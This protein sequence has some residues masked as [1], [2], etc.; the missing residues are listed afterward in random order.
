MM[1]LLPLAVGLNI[2]CSS[3]AERAWLDELRRRQEGE[4]VFERAVEYRIN[5]YAVSSA[6]VP[7]AKARSLHQWFAT[8][9]SSGTLTTSVATF[10][11][12]LGAPEPVKT[13]LNGQVYKQRYRF[14]SAGLDSVFFTGSTDEADLTAR[15]YVYGGTHSAFS[16]IRL[17]GVSSTTITR[18]NAPAQG[19]AINGGL[20]RHP[21]SI[22]TPPPGE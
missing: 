19:P 2:A 18:D 20:G 3:C 16:D 17:N 9:G 15:M 8:G 22:G 6:L 13:T 7:L 12:L 11:S 1:L 4:V 21:R 10:P 5:A 14:T